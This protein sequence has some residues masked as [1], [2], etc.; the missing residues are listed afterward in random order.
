MVA[1]TLLEKLLLLVLVAASILAGTDLFVVGLAY[2]VAGIAR[3]GFDLVSIVRS[4]DVMFAR[5]SP[6][7]GQARDSTFDALRAQSRLAE[8]HSP[9]GHIRPGLLS[10]VAAG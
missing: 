8:H 9:I 3:L 7:S 5:P 2:L 10:P 6:R 1:A 4:Q